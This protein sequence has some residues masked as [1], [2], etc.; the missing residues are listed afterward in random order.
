MVT[1]IQYKELYVLVLHGSK[2]ICADDFKTKHIKGKPINTF[3]PAFNSENN[4]DGDENMEQLAADCGIRK[5][6]S[7]MVQ[8]FP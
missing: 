1:L 4:S 5:L 6:A 2:M 3:M 7:V 8:D